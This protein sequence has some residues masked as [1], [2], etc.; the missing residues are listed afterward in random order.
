MITRKETSFG[1]Q[2]IVIET[3]K[4]AKQAS[5]AVWVQMGDTVVLTTVVGAKEAKPDQGFFPLTVDYREKTY[6]AGKFPGGY[7]KREARP[8]ERGSPHETGPTQR[9]ARAG[10]RGSA[11]QHGASGLL[12]PHACGMIIQAPGRDTPAA[13]LPPARC[14]APPGGKRG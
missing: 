6:A 9:S 12:S 1:K 3:G 13:Q 7:F 14:D 4:L 11:R 5:G 8:T 10:P 2:T